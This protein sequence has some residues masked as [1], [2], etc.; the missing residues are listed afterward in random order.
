MVDFI[1]LLDEVGRLSCL[2]TIFVYIEYLRVELIVVVSSIYCGL[3]L[4]I[5]MFSS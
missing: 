3:P 4:S 1:E 5:E 2:A